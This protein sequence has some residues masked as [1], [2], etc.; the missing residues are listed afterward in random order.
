MIILGWIAAFF[1]FALFVAILAKTKHE[2]F[3]ESYKNSIKALFFILSFVGLIGFLVFFISAVV[4]GI[5]KYEHVDKATVLVCNNV[6]VAESINGFYYEDKGNAYRDYRNNLT[7]TP[8][9]GEVC[10]ELLK[11]S[12]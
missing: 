11:E 12:N 4:V 9:Q 5:A 2:T 1:L 10:K 6:I 7:Y 3:L 8:R